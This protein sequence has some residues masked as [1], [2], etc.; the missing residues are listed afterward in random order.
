MR[1]V[2]SGRSPAFLNIY[3]APTFYPQEATHHMLISYLAAV[4]S[5]KNS[6]MALRF[7]DSWYVY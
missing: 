1:A 5:T 4:Y 3:R 7:A 6:H 2:V